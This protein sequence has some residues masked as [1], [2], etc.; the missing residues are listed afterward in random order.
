MAESRPVSPIDG[1]HLKDDFHSN[2]SA[3][4][5]TTGELLW[6]QVAIGNAG[7]FAPVASPYGV[8]RHTT[9]A[10]ADGDG[11]VLRLDEDM[12]YATAGVG[13]ISFRVKYPDVNSNALAGNNFRI[14]LSA[15]VTAT[16][17]TD[18]ICVE[19]DAGV[20]TLRVD[21]ADHGDVSAAAS[22]VST[23]T[24]GTTMVLDT[25]HLFEI[26]WSGENG[27]GGPKYIDLFIDK[28]PAASVLAVIDDDES[29]EL[30]IVHWQDSGGAADLEFDIDFIEYFHWRPA[31]VTASAV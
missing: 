8:L 11:D 28:E 20:I 22:G 24:S 3:G 6:E 21:S 18:S 17:P 14:G 7:T 5:A 13:G 15:S 25:W 10:T 26:K 29:M 1:I 2:D 4:D 31:T 12:L 16:A 19:S 23:L 27:Q 30:S 9:D